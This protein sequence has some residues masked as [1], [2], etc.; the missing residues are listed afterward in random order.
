MLLTLK[1]RVRTWKNLALVF[2]LN[3]VYVIPNPVSDSASNE[4]ICPSPPQ[5]YPCASNP[6]SVTDSAHHSAQPKPD[7]RQSGCVDDLMSTLPH[8]T[9]VRELEN[10]EAGWSSLR[11]LLEQDG[12][13]DNEVNDQPFS[14]CAAWDEY[15]PSPCDAS[16]H[17]EV[18]SGL[19]STESSNWAVCVPGPSTGRPRDWI[20]TEIA[21]TG[22]FLIGR[23]ALHDVVT[24]AP[25]ST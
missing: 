3:P 11:G 10:I 4:G 14:E 19:E 23:L 16:V 12:G 5:V 22:S 20:Q 1:P 18:S 8:E 15:D 6:E 13:S 17:A 25:A 9:N 7:L 24:H 21:R 2:C